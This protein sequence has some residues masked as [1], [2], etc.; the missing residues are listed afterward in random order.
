M[1]GVF[2][3]FVA[4]AGKTEEYWCNIVHQDIPGLVKQ[5]HQHHFAPYGDEEE[6]VRKL[7]KREEQGF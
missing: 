1:N 7:H 6:F 2:A 4:I 5:P 3:Y